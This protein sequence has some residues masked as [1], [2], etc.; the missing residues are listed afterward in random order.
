MK[1]TALHKQLWFAILILIS[2]LTTLAQPVPLNAETQ[3][4][5]RMGFMADTFTDLSEEDVLISVEVYMKKILENTNIVPQANI[6]YNIEDLQKAL[7][8]QTIEMVA[9][10]TFDYLRSPTLNSFLTPSISRVYNDQNLFTTYVLLVRKNQNWTS[11]ADI[12]NATLRIPKSESIIPTWLDVILAQSGH[13]KSSVFLS[14]QSVTNSPTQALLSVFFEQADACIVNTRTFDIMSQLNPQISKNLMPLAQSPGYMAHLMCFH[15]DL[16][17]SD[18]QIFE[19]QALQLP[20]TPEGRHLLKV[21][22]S[23]SLLEFA[24][25]HIQSVKD[26]IENYHKYYDPIS[27]K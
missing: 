9:I 1:L 16:P 24:P 22:K 23:H 15:K 3:K 21:F 10:S 17:T 5:L 13:P 18:V 7:R 26:L 20:Q 11:L 12:K 25:Q 27:D 2:N 6:F 14:K 19:T 8:N 4:S